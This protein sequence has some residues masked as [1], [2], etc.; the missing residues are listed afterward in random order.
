M[1]FLSRRQARWG[2]SKAGVK[3]LGGASAVHD[4][5]QATD[6]STLPNYTGTTKEKVKPMADGKKKNWIAGAIKH[7]GS[8]RSAA[9]KAG[10][11]TKQFA[12]AHKGDSGK[13]GARARLAETLMGFNK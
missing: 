9:K 4:W 12:N 2:H 3:A 5:D 6:Y 11:S 13:T 1:P 8:L 7:K 10:Q